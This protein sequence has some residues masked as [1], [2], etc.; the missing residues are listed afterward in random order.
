MRSKKQSVYEGPPFASDPTIE[1]FSE[2]VFSTKKT[3]A[4]GDLLRIKRTRGKFK[5]AR[6][7]VSPSRN[8][9][10]ID[11]IDSNGQFRAFYVCDIKGPVPVR[12]SKKIG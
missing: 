2:Y 4:P 11:V 9:E 5:F 6:H 7:V 8:A 10:W 12:R 1:V 3:F